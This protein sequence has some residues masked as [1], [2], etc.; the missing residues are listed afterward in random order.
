MRV[1][2]SALASI[3]AILGTPLLCPGGL[4]PCCA[5]VTSCELADEDCDGGCG[6]EKQAGPCEC[7]CS[8]PSPEN[9]C[10]TCVITC[11]PL[12]LLDAGPQR[13]SLEPSWCIALPP[14]DSCAATNPITSLSTDGFRETLR[15]RFGLASAALPLQI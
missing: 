8:D 7:P 5:P 4:I 15:D 11:A 10:P 2:V 13:P 12:T 14:V 9:E 6:D 3:W 1:Y